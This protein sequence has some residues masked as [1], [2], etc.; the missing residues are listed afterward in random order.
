MVFL[1]LVTAGCGPRV[2]LTT[3]TTIGLKATPG[4]GYTRPPQVTFGYKRAEAAV[5]PTK[6]T[7]ALEGEDAYST[8]AAFH[9]STEFFGKTELDSFIST[10]RAALDIQQ[11]AFTQEIAAAVVAFQDSRYNNLAQLSSARRI[12]E[13]YKALTDSNKRQRIRDKAMEL[14]LVPPATTDAEFANGKVGDAAVGGLEP[15]TLKFRELE[16]F[17]AAVITQ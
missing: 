1:G 10:G 14:K 15:I 13:A 5:V 7:V 11:P 17:T 2:I 3:G 16:Q 9:F 12:T 6:G 4:D 8:L